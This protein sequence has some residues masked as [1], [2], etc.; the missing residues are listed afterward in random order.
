MRSNDLP[1]EIYELV[2]EITRDGPRTTLVPVP[3]R[4]ETGEA[5]RVAVDHAAKPSD[6]ASSTSSAGASS[7]CFS[8]RLVSSSRCAN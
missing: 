1:I 2:V 8:F 6:V 3:Y 7:P 5:E 4:V